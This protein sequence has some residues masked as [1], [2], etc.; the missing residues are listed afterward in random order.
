MSSWSEAGGGDDLVGG[1]GQL[2][3]AVGQAGAG[4]DEGVGVGVFGL[5]EFGQQVQVVAEGLQLLVGFFR[6]EIAGIAWRSLPTALRSRNRSYRSRTAFS[7]VPTASGGN[8]QWPSPTGGSART[9]WPR[10]LSVASAR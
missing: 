3:E 9:F 10:P 1:F 6:Q 4:Q 8:P 2:G 7:A 5:A